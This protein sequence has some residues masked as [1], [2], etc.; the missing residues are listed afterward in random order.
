ML[1]NIYTGLCRVLGRKGHLPSSELL[2]MLVT[3][4][5]VVI[6]HT[7]FLFI[8][9]RYELTFLVE[10]YGTILFGLSFFLFSIMYFRLVKKFKIYSKNIK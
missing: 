8:I 4:L 9:F 5:T 1:Q 7:V 10:D 2:A 3:V 6:T